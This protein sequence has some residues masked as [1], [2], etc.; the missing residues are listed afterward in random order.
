MK[1]LFTADW[2]FGAVME[3]P[4]K[5]AEHLVSRVI[6][7]LNQRAKEGDVVY[8]VGDA[9]TRGVSLL[10]TTDESG[11]RVKTK[12]EGSR[13]KIGDYLS[14]IVADVILIEG[15]HCYNNAV[16]P[17]IKVGFVD[18]GRYIAFLSHYPTTFDK[19]VIFDFREQV[20]WHRLIQA[21]AVVADFA[22]VG[23]V[24]GQWKHQYDNKLGLWNLNVGI[25][26]NDWLPVTSEEVVHE[27]EHLTERRK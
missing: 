2:H 21:A 3:R 16:K 18:V 19:N 26:V 25:D 9:V 4:F 27:F 11:Q 20:R 8:H 22:L 15:N 24:H 12:F 5:S 14:Q 10:I 23:H 1:K 13:L 6:T 17:H 7:G